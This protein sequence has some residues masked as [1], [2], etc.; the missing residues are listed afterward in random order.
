MF[1]E[2][3]EANGTFAAAV[4]LSYDPL[5]IGNFTLDRSKLQILRSNPVDGKDMRT[6]A[7]NGK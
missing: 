3:H 1:G 4:Q 2:F 6:E 5:W 7:L